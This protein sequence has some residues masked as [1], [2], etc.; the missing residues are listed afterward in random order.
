M[1]ASCP[2]SGAFAF[3]VQF[4]LILVKQRAQGWSGMQLHLHPSSQQTLE[5]V[6]ADLGRKS[7]EKVRFFWAIPGPLS[8]PRRTI[9]LEGPLCLPSVGPLG[10]PSLD[11][12]SSKGRHP[13]V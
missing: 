3:R 4:W 1:P 6:L 11:M 8:L 7:K 10:A 2:L 13:S 5:I 12:G 9:G